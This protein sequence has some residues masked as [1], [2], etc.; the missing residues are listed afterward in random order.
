[1]F[2]QIAYKIARDQFHGK[3]RE[4]F[5]VLSDDEPKPDQDLG[6][7]R[8]SLDPRPERSRDRGRK[9]PR[10]SDTMSVDSFAKKPDKSKSAEKRK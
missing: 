7:R 8:L 4:T 6:A 3:L 10:D 9:H 2:L 1:M 5:L